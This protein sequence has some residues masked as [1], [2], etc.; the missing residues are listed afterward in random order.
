MPCCSAAHTAAPPSEW[1][2]ATREASRRPIRDLRRG[3]L[4][5]QH[6]QERR[7]LEQPLHV[8]RAGDDREAQAA[9]VGQFLSEQDRPQPRGVDER[10]L[11]EIEHDG[12][13]PVGG[14]AYQRLLE[15]GGRE[16][17]QFAAQDEHVPASLHEVTCPKRLV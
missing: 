5:R 15:T 2:S 11:P 16:D 10:R 7:H 4:E 6:L 12:G 1:R 3:L 17:V 13:R 14:E 9:F 8:R